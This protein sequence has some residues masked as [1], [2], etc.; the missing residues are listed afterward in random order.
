MEI[1]YLVNVKYV[2]EKMVRV[3]K[4][5]QTVA[6]DDYT[7]CSHLDPF[8]VWSQKRTYHQIKYGYQ[9]LGVKPKWN[10]SQDGRGRTRRSRRH[11]FWKQTSQFN[12]RKHFELINPR[13]GLPIEYGE[14]RALFEFEF[15]ISSFYECHF[16]KSIYWTF[17]KKCFFPSRSISCRWLKWNRLRPSR[18]FENY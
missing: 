12:R 13:Y 3:Q 2:F 1:I 9:Y 10:I 15:V 8:D 18:T 17:A 16:F 14:S 11:L 6:A 7:Q 4:R 5:L